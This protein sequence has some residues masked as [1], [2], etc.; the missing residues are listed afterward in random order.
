[1]NWENGK[2]QPVDVRILHRIIV[3]LGYDPLPKGTSISDLLR[4]KRR[5]LGMRQRDLA[6]RFGVDQ[7]VIRDWESD[8]TILKYRH[9]QL[10][11][12]FIGIDEVAV[13]QLMRKRWVKGH[14]AVD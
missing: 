11:A 4:A 10:V 9:R 2:Y 14:G 12:N 8:R 7:S 13:E 6:A 5:E 1:V 3:F